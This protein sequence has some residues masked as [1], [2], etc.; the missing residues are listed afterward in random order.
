[1][2][3]TKHEYTKTIVRTDVIESMYIDQRAY[4]DQN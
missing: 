4:D 1:M 2:G 3:A